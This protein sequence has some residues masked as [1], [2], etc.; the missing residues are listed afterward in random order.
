[1]AEDELSD[2]LDYLSINAKQID[3]KL[4]EFSKS[5]ALLSSENPR[6]ID[7]YDD[8][9]VAVHKGRIAA[10]G[11]TFETLTNK[12]EEIGIPA[13]E[14]IVRHIDRESRTFIF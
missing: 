6:L 5:A 4:A 9:W 14:T 11:E 2:L 12:L 1:M 10:S 7:Q 3:Q 8:T 13:S